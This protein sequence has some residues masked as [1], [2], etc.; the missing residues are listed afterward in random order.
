LSYGEGD[1][2][3]TVLRVR[4]PDMCNVKKYANVLQLDKDIFKPFKKCCKC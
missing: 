2:V 3:S 4:I 1:I